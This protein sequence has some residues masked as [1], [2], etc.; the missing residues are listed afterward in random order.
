[1][2]L[3]TFVLT[4]VFLIFPIIFRNRISDLVYVFVAVCFTSYIC[5]HYGILRVESSVWDFGISVVAIVV[6]SVVYKNKYFI[7]R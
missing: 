6:V 1:M 3:L 5:N 4:V 2:D 7:F